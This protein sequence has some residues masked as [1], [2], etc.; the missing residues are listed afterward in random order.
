MRCSRAATARKAPASAP[1]FT[2][3]Y[4]GEPGLVIEAP[5]TGVRRPLLRPPLTGV[6]SWALSPLGDRIAFVRRKPAA[7]AGLYVVRRS[8]RNARRVQRLSASEA[9]ATRV[10]AWTGDASTIVR[11]SSSCG[12]RPRPARISLTTGAKSRTLQL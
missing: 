4:E 12:D 9:A 1:P 10:V 5:E 7:G 2:A 8:G 3:V 6:G 11:V